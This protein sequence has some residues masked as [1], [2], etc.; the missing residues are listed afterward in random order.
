M[1]G[2]GID[3]VEPR[4]LTIRNASLNAIVREPNGWRVL[5]W[6]EVDHLD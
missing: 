3:H 6:G 1:A 2:A 5:A 4:R